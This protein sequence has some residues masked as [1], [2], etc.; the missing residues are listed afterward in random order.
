MPPAS[1]EFHPEAIQEAR[2]AHD[3]YRA[4]NESA[5]S[6]FLNELE[7]ALERVRQDPERWP[8]AQDDTRRLLFRRFPFSLVY[9]VSS[10][11]VLV[12][13]VA[14]DRRRPGYW[15]HRVG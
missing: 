12:I 13:A 9:R 1:L 14:H 5:A 11:N 8:R 4:R 3:W 15:R 2:A 6:A 10:V 7:S